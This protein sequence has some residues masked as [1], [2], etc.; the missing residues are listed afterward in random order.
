MDIFPGSLGDEARV[1]I[2]NPDDFTA[3]RS[4]LR[5]ILTA[6]AAYQADFGRYASNLRQPD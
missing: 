6:Q 1:G 3:V 2:E 4:D 5:N